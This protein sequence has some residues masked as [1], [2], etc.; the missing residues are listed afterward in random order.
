MP[1]ISLFVHI[2]ITSLCSCENYK[3]VS[4]LYYRFLMILVLKMYSDHIVS[5]NLIK[6]R[7]GK[8]NWKLG[9]NCTFVTMPF[10]WKIY[11]GFVIQN[12]SH[13]WSVLFDH[14]K[15]LFLYLFV[16]NLKQV[17]N[18]L[19]RQSFFGALMNLMLKI[20]FYYFFDCF[21][22]FFTECKLF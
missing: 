19:N 16:L 2:L 1:Q 5:W 3:L 11:I 13:L 12:V 6:M 8:I 9:G 15:V 14:N 20:V 22:N 7:D 21:Y 10:M 18:Y 4:I 17:T